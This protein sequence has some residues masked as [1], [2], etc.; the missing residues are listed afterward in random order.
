VDAKER[1]GNRFLGFY[2]F[3]EVGGYQLDSN[4]YRP[5]READNITDASKRFIMTIDR[6]L[7]YIN[8][9]YTESTSFPL[10]TSDY[11]LYWFDYKGGYN[12]VLAQLGWNYS[13]Q[14]N[15]AQVRGAATVQGKEWGTIITWTYNDPP[16]IESGP[17]LYNDLVLA[18]ENGAKYIVIFDSN[19]DYSGGILKN[20]HLEAMRHFWRYSK[21]NPRNAEAIVARIA[22][23]LPKGYAYGFRGPTDTIWGL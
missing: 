14:L 8:V 12:V 9:G 5:V 7:N 15:I 4:Q 17:E 3:D 2:A 20:E 10:F 13:R 18:Y 23:V 19:K 16:Y 21:E 11:A 6:S 22:F 1:W